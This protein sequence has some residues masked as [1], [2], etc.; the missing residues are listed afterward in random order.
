MRLLILGGGSCQVNAIKQ[1]KALGHTVI[2]S[3]YYPDAPGKKFSDYSELVST[4]DIEGNIRIAKQ[5]AVDGVM[6][7][8]TDQPVYTAAMVACQLGLPSFINPPTARAVTNKRDMKLIFTKEGI[9]TVNYRLLKEGFSDQELTGISFPVVVKPLD[10]Q[11]QR[12]VYKLDSLEEVRDKFADV[13]CFSREEEI[14]I[15]EFYPSDEITV[16]GWVEN[17]RAYL[18]TITDR[19]TYENDHHIGICTAHYFPSHYLKNHYSEIKAIS[20]QIVTAFNI[21][22]GPIYFQL[23]IGED[24]IK[25][26]E[27]TC[28]IG[29]AYEDLF[30]PVITGVNIMKMMIDTVLGIELETDH[31]KTYHLLNNKNRLTVQLFFARAGKIRK[32][33]PPAEIKKL[34]GVIDMGYNFKEGDRIGEIKNATERAGFLIV[35]EE[36]QKSLEDNL[37]RALDQLAI[38]NESRENL[39]LKS[40]GKYRN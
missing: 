38:Y 9:P 29:G 28:R 4:F 37:E 3:D 15:E 33:T 16:S 31:L 6:T 13:L 14:L 10:S 7:S 40:I 30:I 11:G 39:V 34:P 26:N 23:L 35:R 2:V 21:Q 17:G 8:G 24:G 19:L 25:V 36:D 12:G 18:L 27:I 20:E 22:N 1:A 5:Y 32:M